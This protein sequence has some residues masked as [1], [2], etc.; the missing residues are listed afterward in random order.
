MSYDA[1]KVLDILE[2]IRKRP[3]MYVGRT[4]VA[5]HLFSEVLDNCLDEAMAGHATQ[6]HISFSITDGVD[7]VTIQDN[8][9]GIPHSR[10]EEKDEYDIII[11]ATVAHS[12]GKFDNEA[13]KVAAGLHGVGLVAVNALSS[14]L[15]IES[16]RDGKSLTAIFEQQETMELDSQFVDAP[17]GTR[18]TFTPD[19]TCWDHPVVDRNTARERCVLAATFIPGLQIYFDGD[20]INPMDESELLSH[21]V[22]TD[23]MKISHVYENGEEFQSW[24]GWD[25]T[26]ADCQTANG[27]VN[28][29][30]VHQGL[31]IKLITK[32]WTDYFYS[33]LSSEDQT[34]FALNDFLV[35]LRTFTLVKLVDPSYTSQTKETLS[36][37]VRDY[38]DMMDDMIKELAKAVPAGSTLYKALLAKYR[39][40]RKYLN[41]QSSSRY[42]DEVL[43]FGD[44]G[45]N[46]SRGRNLESKL[47]DCSSSN[48][49]GT[50]LFIVEG[51]S[52]GGGL[53]PLRDRKKH[54]ILPLRGKL[55]NTVDVEI[56]DL[57]DNLEVRSLVNALG[58][59][60]LHKE[61]P[62]C[63]RYSKII[64]ATDADPDG[65]NIAALLIGALCY[66]CPRTVEAG[67][68]YIA[69]APL[70]G[71]IPTRKVNG[72]KFIPVWRHEDANPNW[73]TKRFKGLGSM[74][75][76]QLFTS[77]ADPEYRKLTQVTMDNRQSVLD[78]VAG[79][80]YR[81]EY[82]TARGIVRLQ[83]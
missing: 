55:M 60:V 45:G 39:D 65:K 67:H 2:A 56:K 19:P 4:E 68:V 9:R 34:Y 54:A 35:G 7:T 81:R 23:V 18:V 71:Q 79:G 76:D 58:V 44:E 80:S 20:L 37:S 15:E 57:L 36:G 38:R 40:Y 75:P 50:E 62:D 53:A 16:V 26:K 48:R 11:A 51:D 1:L 73:K 32:A 27:S 70:F 22:N 78:M 47:I 10:N 83:G 3:G 63:V 12:G 14:H 59:G 41:S 13:Y 28:L 66:L 77:I 74:Q 5:T 82:L 69:H 8:G 24:I 46:I 6:I 21:D 49:E 64:I 29:L 25:L 31:H 42:L 61:N 30:P 17:N 33:T 43:E 72:R 52:A